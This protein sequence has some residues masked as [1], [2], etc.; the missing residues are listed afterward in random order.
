MNGN[1][2]RITNPRQQDQQE[3][4]NRISNS[5]KKERQCNCRS[6]QGQRNNK[7]LNKQLFIVLTNYFII[8]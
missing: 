6:T 5:T 8:H 1:K 7:L 2:A 3:Q 4:H